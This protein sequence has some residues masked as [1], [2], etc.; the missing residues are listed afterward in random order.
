MD[1]VHE[2]VRVGL[3]PVL[4]QPAHRGAAEARLSCNLPVSPR[5][6]PRSTHTTP[7]PKSAALV[8]EAPRNR[9]SAR[10]SPTKAHKNTN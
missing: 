7:T 3:G 10:E 5:A 4:G 8:L 9:P 2:A 6:F 1:G